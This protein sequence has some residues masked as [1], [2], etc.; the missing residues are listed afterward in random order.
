M[1]AMDLFALPGGLGLFLFG[2]RTMSEGLER[3]AGGCLR[4]LLER[5]TRSR[6]L[7]V[8]TG[9]LITA[10]IQSSSAATVMTVGF[11]Q[12][13][14]MTLRQ[15]ASI[16][17]G[18]NIGTTAT[19]LMLSA[20]VDF[21]AVFA[22]AGLVLMFIPK[23][24]AAARS[25]GSVLIGLGVLF[26]G[27]DAMSDAVH[28]LREL[29]EFRTAMAQVSHPLAGLAVGAIVTAVIQ[30]SSASIGILQALAGE[31]LI[32]L[33]GALYILFGQNIGTCI[34]AML[35]CAGASCEAKR[36]AVI[37]LLFNLIGAGLMTMASLLLP[38][39]RWIA[40]LAPDSARLQIA[41]AHILFNL[42]TTAMLLPASPLLERLACSII[43]QTG[44]H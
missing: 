28:P 19:S 8:T 27:M 23:R 43:R 29:P 40:A 18:A 9:A 7:G 6:L 2:M 39:D 13:G 17:M 5:V 42:A 41:L 34:T 38:L 30:S 21:G 4:P 16:I 26:A 14:L 33:N 3:T 32:G 25:F 44:R 15:A 20:K 35:A 22:S 10:L 12:A 37:H 1:A 36:A 31:G 24:F 11:I